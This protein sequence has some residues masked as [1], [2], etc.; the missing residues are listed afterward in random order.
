[1]PTFFLRTSSCCDDIAVELADPLT[2]WAELKATCCDLVRGAM[3]G[4]EPDRPWQ[5]ELHDESHTPVYEICITGRA[6]IA[7]VFMLAVPALCL[8][9]HGQAAA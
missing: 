2:A 5:I 8:A 9:F 3:A 7:V 1:M 6:L 4:L